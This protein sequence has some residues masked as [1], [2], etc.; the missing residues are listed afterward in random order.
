MYLKKVKF[1]DDTVFNDKEELKNFN[2]DLTDIQKK[3]E[4]MY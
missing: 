3:N 1:S 2:N 4:H